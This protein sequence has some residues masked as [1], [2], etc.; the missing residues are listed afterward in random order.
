LPVCQGRGWL[1]ASNRL[2][3][4]TEP[5]AV[6]VRLTCPSHSIQ[7]PF[8]ATRSDI[9]R[10]PAGGGWMVSAPWS[11]MYIATNRLL[12]TAPRIGFF[13]SVS[14]CTGAEAELAGARG[15]TLGF[16]SVAG[17]LD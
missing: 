3:S 13:E 11:I 5:Y 17:S 14:T 7:K 8:V 6:N 16:R 4:V 9:A 12:M 1:N 10:G 15:N 2:A